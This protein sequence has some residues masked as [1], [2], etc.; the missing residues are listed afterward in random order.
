MKGRFL[1]IGAFQLPD[2]NA[3]AQRVLGIAKLLRLLEYEVVFLDFNKDVQEF[4]DVPHDI[5]GFETYSQPY[6]TDLKQWLRHALSP[7][8]VQEVLQKHNDWKGVIAYNYP[9]IALRRLTSLCHKQNILALADCTEWYAPDCSN[10]HRMAVTIDSCLRMRWAQKK[11]NGVIAISSYLAEYYQP[12][13]KVVTLPPL[14]DIEDGKWKRTDEVKID[15][16]INLYY[17]GSPGANLEKDRLDVI[18]NALDHC[19]SSAKMAF[20]VVGITEIQ[21]IEVFPDC[22]I[23]VDRLKQQDSLIFHG[24]LPHREAIALLKN[25]DYSIFLR[26]QNRMTMAG[27]PTKFVESITCAVP[28]ITNDTSDLKKYL[29]DGNNG[30]LVEL[31]SDNIADMFASLPNRQIDV[32]RESFDI[33][34]YSTEVQGFLDSISI[35]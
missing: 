17:V 5:C 20:H 16:R 23:T 26:S 28:V 11:V 18:I 9:A 30:I 15:D 1:Y 10:L 3:A 19:P 29:S 32:K 35:D 22:Q 12:Y 34:K 4:I 27:F 33:R 31:N 2:K 6:P 13:T 8:H 7:M 24:R 21:F 25:A 14:V